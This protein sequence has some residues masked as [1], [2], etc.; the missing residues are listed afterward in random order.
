MDRIL[1]RRRRSS[2]R[3]G[4]AFEERLRLDGVC[5]PRL[6]G[7]CSPRTGARRGEREW[8]RRP[9]EDSNRRPYPRARQ[10][11]RRERRGR[12]PRGVNDARRRRRAK[13]RV[14]GEAPRPNPLGCHRFGR[15]RGRS[16]CRGRSRP[17]HC[18]NRRLRPR[19][20]RREAADRREAYR[21]HG[22]RLRRRPIPSSRQ[23]QP[24]R[25]RLRVRGRSV[26]RRRIL[27]VDS[28]ESTNDLRLGRRR[29]GRG[30][31]V[32]HRGRGGRVRHRG[33]GGRVRL[34]G[35]A[36]S[37]ERRPELRRSDLGR[38]RRRL[39]RR[40]NEVEVR[41]RVPGRRRRGSERGDRT[42]RR[43]SRSGLS[44]RRDPPANL[45]R[46]R[47]H[48]R[49]TRRRRRAK[50][51]GGARENVIRRFGFGAGAVGCT[52]APRDA[53]P[54]HRRNRNRR[55]GNGM[56]RD[57]PRPECFRLGRFLLRAR[58]RRRL[59]VSPA[60]FLRTPHAP[61]DA[62]PELVGIARHR[63]YGP[64]EA[65]PHLPKRALALRQ[66]PFAR[67]QRVPQRSNRT[68]RPR[69]NLLENVHDLLP[70][71]TRRLVARV[72]RRGYRRDVTRAR[73]IR[74]PLVE[75]RRRV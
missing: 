40:G 26:R 15:P 43:L 5:S 24:V 53:L 63:G 68:R 17:C 61:L 46:P 38:R 56:R 25:L 52:L 54:F 58:R 20:G 48:G 18:G 41:S 51:R 39:K 71:A 8:R 6:G 50:F 33:R 13:G 67:V 10:R 21:L 27:R 55:D 65:P 14:R 19:D 37:C 9:I 62:S 69:V 72:E 66:L 64:D 49:R 57:R 73:L 42:R 28:R 1:R 2:S 75:T 31:R 22:F 4:H 12:R 59:R 3:A 60:S 11:R 36:S 44:R 29:R 35:L 47:E 16:R 7:V 70:G 45:A 23:T 74:V 32:R 34:R 30:G